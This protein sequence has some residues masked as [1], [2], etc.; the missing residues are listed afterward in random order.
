MDDK[1]KEIVLRNSSS[2]TP[3]HLLSSVLEQRYAHKSSSNIKNKTEK[4]DPITFPAMQQA[5]GSMYSTI[6]EIVEEDE[7]E[8]TEN[9][10]EESDEISVDEAMEN[11]RSMSEHLL[12]MVD[13][14]EQNHAKTE[15]KK[16]IE[17]E[18]QKKHDPYN[19]AINSFRS[20]EENLDTIEFSSDIDIETIVFAPP[21]KRSR[22]FRNEA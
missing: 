9:P 5:L 12:G 21:K 6:V 2:S 8:E 20:T 3:A 18:M 7:A 19:R 10:I 13:E 11:V 15:H 17:V 14:I 22:R 16:V 1:K 4:P